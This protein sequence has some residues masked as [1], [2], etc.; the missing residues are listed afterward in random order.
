MYVEEITASDLALLQLPECPEQSNVCL[1]FPVYRERD[2]THGL[3]CL[4]V[5]NTGSSFALFYMP[6]SKNAND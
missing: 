1:L 2:F 3:P 4:R 5:I 6:Y